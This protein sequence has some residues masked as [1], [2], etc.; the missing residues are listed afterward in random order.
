MSGCAYGCVSVNFVGLRVPLRLC[1]ACLYECVPVLCTSILVY[2][3]VVSMCVGVL[4]VQVFP[5]LCTWWVGRYVDSMYIPLCYVLHVCC[6]G[7]YVSVTIPVSLCM[8]ASVFSAHTPG[9]LSVYFSSEVLPPA[10]WM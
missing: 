4:Y 7:I 3:Y 1:L 2:P 6:V 10:P 9:F 5:Q 8:C